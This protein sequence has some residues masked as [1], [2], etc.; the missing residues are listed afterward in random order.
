MASRYIPGSPAYYENSMRGV[1][2]SPVTENPIYGPPPPESIERNENRIAR[3]KKGKTF[4]NL[5]NPS[6]AYN[7]KRNAFRRIKGFNWATVKNR[8]K[9][10]F[11]NEQNAKAATRLNALKRH[12]N[13]EWQ[14]YVQQ[15]R[16]KHPNQGAP[17]RISFGYGG[18]N[19]SR[20]RRRT[21]KRNN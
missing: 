5:N 8:V 13:A 19:T 10:G 7:A 11:K 6:S 12:R 16:E 4:R 14:A 3:E 9:Q 17:P 20:R 21:I 1:A 15:Y 18:G 2:P